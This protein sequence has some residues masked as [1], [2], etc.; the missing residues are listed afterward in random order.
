MG[1]GKGAGKRLPGLAKKPHRYRPGAKALSEIRAYQAGTELLIRKRPFQALVKEVAGAA[2]ANNSHFEGG[3]SFQ[4]DALGA[5]QEAAESY[6]VALF[7]DTNEAC[8][9]ARR[10]TIKPDD[11]RLARRMRGSA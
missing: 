8:L 10:I 9:H 5:L 7:A 2:V 6:L 4:S 3:V 11:M 1:V